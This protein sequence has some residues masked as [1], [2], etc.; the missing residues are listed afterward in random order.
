MSVSLTFLSALGTQEWTQCTASNVLVDIFDSPNAIFGLGYSSYGV[1]QDHAGSL[2]SIFTPSSLESPSLVPDAL[3]EELSSSASA[4]LSTLL[5]WSSLSPSSLNS[6]FELPS[7]SEL[8]SSSVFSLST[9]SS[10]AVK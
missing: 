9:S 4:P 3:S 2:T 1:S 6:A 10:V 8:P 5:V 7:V